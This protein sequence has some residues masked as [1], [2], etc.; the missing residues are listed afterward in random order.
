M[1]LKDNLVAVWE[2]NSN[3]NDSHSTNNLTGVN[4]PGYVSGKFS[5]NAA[6]LASASSQAFTIADNAA[7]SMD[8]ETFSI[9]FWTRI[10]ASSGEQRFISK[11][12]YNSENREYSFALNQGS[13]NRISFMVSADGTGVSAL[14][15]ADSYGAPSVDGS[16][17]VWVYGYHEQGVGIGIS[18]NNGTIDT[19]VHTGGV[20]QGTSPF[21]IGRMY[22]IRYIDADIQQVAVWRKLLTSDDR[23]AIYNGGTGLAFSAWDAASGQPASRRMG[24]VK[25]S[26]T[27]SL[28]MNRW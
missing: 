5:Q 2:L 8:D 15:N 6:R 11:Y 28:G 26:G 10:T 20:H 24:G 25:F 3:G 13:S 21:D 22:D 27:Q 4:T 1:A 9:A 16:T 17:W 18:V 7:L 23:I 19:T 12:D 14:Q